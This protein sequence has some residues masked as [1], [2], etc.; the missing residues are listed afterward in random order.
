MSSTER[1]KLVRDLGRGLR[2]TWNLGTNRSSR[3]Q[4]WSDLSFYSWSSVPVICVCGDGHEDP[5]VLKII[6][7][8]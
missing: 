5:P 4:S 3:T 8:T 1:I 6:I 7:T 2:D